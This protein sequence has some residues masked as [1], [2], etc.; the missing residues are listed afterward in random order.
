M[1]TFR[2]LVVLAVLVVG[3][4]IGALNSQP[5]TVNF[6]F[7]EVVTTSGIAIIVS[8]LAGVIAGG[9]LVLV[10]VA[11]PMYSRLRRNAKLAAGSD[12]PPA[13]AGRT[14]SDGL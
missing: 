9:G 10:G 7:S 13:S 6:I 12:I 4:M 2:L 5:V 3:L 1:K 14:P 8:L 11:L